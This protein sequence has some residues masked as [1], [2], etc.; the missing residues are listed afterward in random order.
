M[1]CWWDPLWSRAC[2]HGDLCAV[3]GN[4]S[5]VLADVSEGKHLMPGP[6]SFAGVAL[7]ACQARCIKE[8]LCLYFAL[9]EG[10][11]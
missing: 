11:A 3:A 6:S 4:F 8:V 7:G 5:T 2:L 10:E 9:P 1:H